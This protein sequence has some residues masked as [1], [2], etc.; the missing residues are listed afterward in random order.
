MSPISDVTLRR[1][2]ADDAAVYRPFRLAALRATPA[3]FTST[4]T[5]EEARP[6]GWSAQRLAAN[7]ILGAF[8]PDLCGTAG[9]SLPPRTQERHKATLFGMA[10]AASRGGR[11]IGRQLVEAILDHAA[12]LPHV[13]QVILSVSEG[14]EAAVRLYRACGFTVYGREPRAVMIEG[15][16]IAKLHMIRMLGS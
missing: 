13:T 11:G 12:A 3:A 14:N 4:W 8:G 6:P 2:T 1:L 7:F 15:E 10:V 5:E 16:A 9:L